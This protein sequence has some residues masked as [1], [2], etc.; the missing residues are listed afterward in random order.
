MTPDMMVLCLSCTTLLIAHRIL[1]TG[2]FS[3]ILDLLNLFL[4][5]GL[6]LAVSSALTVLTG[7]CLAA[8]HHLGRA[9]SSKWSVSLSS[10]KQLSSNHLILFDFHHSLFLFWFFSSLSELS[11]T[12]YSIL[13]FQGLEEYLAHRRWSFTEY[14]NWIF[15]SYWICRIWI[16]QQLPLTF[17][18]PSSNLLS[19][20]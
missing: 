6:L 17:V 1:A 9:S 14:L 20:L 10:S 16:S 3:L 18:L 2:T 4:H 11:S 12:S 7:L 5:W 13:Y 19:T 15:R 8:P